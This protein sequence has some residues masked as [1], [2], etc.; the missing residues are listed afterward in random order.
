MRA[1]EAEKREVKKSILKKESWRRPSGILRLRK[2]AL[3]SNDD[4]PSTIGFDN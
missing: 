1:G 2:C 3:G 4:D